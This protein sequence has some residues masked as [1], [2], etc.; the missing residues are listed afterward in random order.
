MKE[1][2]HGFSVEHAEECK[3]DYRWSSGSHGIYLYRE[4]Y[5]ESPNGDNWSY[6]DPKTLCII[7]YRPDNS[8]TAKMREVGKHVAGPFPTLDAAKVAFM[9]IYGGRDG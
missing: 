9:L 4:D 7:D 8:D 3:E 2:A 5:D 1:I 6:I